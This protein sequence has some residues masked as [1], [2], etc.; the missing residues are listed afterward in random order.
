M[1]KSD[2][3]AEITQQ[4]NKAVASDRLKIDEPMSM[5]TTFKIGGPADFLVLPASMQEVSAVLA[6]A[7]CYALPVTVLGNGSNVL[8]LDRGIRGLVV[9]IGE[10]MSSIRRDGE[11]VIA[12]AGALLA[13]VSGFAADSALTG[14]EFAIGIP[15][16][17]GGAVFMNAGAYDGE[18]KN[19]V[20]AVSAVSPDGIITRFDHDEIQFGYRYSI[21]QE[22]H[23]IICEVE[24]GLKHGDPRVIARKMV[25]LTDRRESKQP[26]ELPSAGSTFKRPPGYFAGTLIEQAGL[27]GFR[28]G[29]AQVSDKHAGFIVNAG[30][31]TAADVV[32]L[33]KEVQRRVNEKFGIMLHPEV[34]IIGED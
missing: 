16:S 6:V 15:G 20:R 18:M 33:I 29:G 30:G 7:K 4:L 28:V 34:R 31:A 2:L 24:L 1:L 23:Y 3:R 10:H 21:F 32:K 22:N 12:G 14:M 13:D 25:D 9:K 27:K 17:I 8:V 5:H 11:V 26:L 19:V